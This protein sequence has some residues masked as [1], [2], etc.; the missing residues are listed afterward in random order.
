M[1]LHVEH[2]K[3]SAKKLLTNKKYS[4]K[5]QDTKLAH[6]NQLYFCTITIQ[7][8]KGERHFKSGISRSIFI[9]NISQLV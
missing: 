8:S 7:N 5:L 6:K 9:A 3:D 2:P 4:A 1:I